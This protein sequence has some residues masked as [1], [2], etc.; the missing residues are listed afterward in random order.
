MFTDIPDT[1]ETPV[2][3][4]ESSNQD[5]SMDVSDVNELV[6]NETLENPA[7]VDINEES[8][9]N[10]PDDTGMYIFYEC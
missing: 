2:R 10:R 4:E 9:L 6:E 7:E 3:E 8:F 1:G 5:A